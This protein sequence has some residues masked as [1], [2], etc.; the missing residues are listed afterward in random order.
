LLIDEY[1]GRWSFDR[2]FLRQVETMDETT[3]TVEPPQQSGLVLLRLANRDFLD[4]DTTAPMGLDAAAGQL[5]YAGATGKLQW[6]ATSDFD[7]TGDG[8]GVFCGLID[9][10]QVVEIGGCLFTAPATS[11]AV[12][13]TA[14]TTAFDVS[15]TIHANYLRAPSS[16]P[17][18]LR[19]SAWV[20]YSVVAA[21]SPT[22][23]LA[24][25]LGASNFAVFTFTTVVSAANR[26][27][28]LECVIGMRGQGAAGSARGLGTFTDG[29]TTG[30]TRVA[31]APID[32]TVANLLS[33]TCT[34]GTAAVA[35][36]ATL[37]GLTVEA[38]N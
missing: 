2:N 25:K 17:R 27:C 28:K 36:A 4:G 15:T 3:S 8:Q 38:L 23:T 6:L 34:W 12:A 22:L 21:T 13:N 35:N 16:N 26:M 18:T 7:S 11:S 37:E 14:L 10:A 19:V 24:V 32:T 30:V 29:A 31:S 9:F 33:I 1:L 5:T 20:R